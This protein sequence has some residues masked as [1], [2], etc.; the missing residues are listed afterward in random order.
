M[1]NAAAYYTK[2]SR[3]LHNYANNGFFSRGLDADDFAF[4]EQVR[5][6]G[7]MPCGSLAEPVPTACT[8]S[9]DVYSRVALLEEMQFWQQPYQVDKIA[10]RRSGPII[11]ARP[12][13]SG[14]TPF[15]IKRKLDREL[16]AK[17]KAE[18][19]QRLHERQLEQ[20]RRDIEWEKAAPKPKRKFGRVID[21]HYVPQWRVEELDAEA[22][23]KLEQQQRIAKD[24]RR[25]R[26][27]KRMR[28]HVMAAK[29]R[30]ATQQQ[31]QA[32]CEAAYAKQRLEREALA[33][34]HFRETADNNPITR[35]V[36][37]NLKIRILQV[38]HMSFPNMVTLESM[39]TALPYSDKEFLLRC[40]EEL[41]NEGRLR[42]KTEDVAA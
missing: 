26:E 32:A 28:E 9:D 12:A 13:P 31:N 27:V 6:R 14:T 42:R 41:I 20:L 5:E 40:I 36:K 38:M 19:Q 18:E 30:F 2:Y 17:A 3:A 39:M 15:A 35:I 21:R 16:V 8:Y 29:K 33:T 23:R 25:R 11:R 22:K 10:I 34:F 7:C 37:E 24:A 4:V 1:S